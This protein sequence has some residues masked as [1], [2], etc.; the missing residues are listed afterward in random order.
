VKTGSLND[1]RTVAGY[2]LDR[3]GHRHVVVFFVN[4]PTA[5]LSQPAQDALLKWVHDVAR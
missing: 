4:H 2:V 1:V 3:N 5:H